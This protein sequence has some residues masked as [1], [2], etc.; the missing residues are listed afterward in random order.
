MKEVAIVTGAS[1]GI[2][3]EIAKLF[4]SERTNLLVAARDEQKLLNIK[5]MF[6]EQYGISVLTVATD[7]TSIEGVQAIHDTVNAN[8]LT[9][10]YL[11]NNA[12]FGD[13]G[14]FINS[15]IG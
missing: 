9:V 5:K 15:S 1:T 7:L 11:V 3:Y 8:S 14:P 13:Y 2:G 10:R 4:A 12:G 6:E